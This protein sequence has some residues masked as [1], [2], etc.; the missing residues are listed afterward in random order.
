MTQSWKVVWYTATNVVNGD[1]KGW[2]TVKKTGVL[3][4]D[5]AD[6][7]KNKIFQDRYG[8]GQMIPTEN[9][10]VDDYGVSKITVRN[11][12]DILVSEGYLQK[13]SGKGTFVISNR[14]FNRLSKADS[15]SAMLEYEGNQLTKK[16]L[17]ISVG[18]E[19]TIPQEFEQAQGQITRIERVYYLDDKPF[20]LFTHYLRVPIEQVSAQFLENH[21]LYQVLKIAGISVK[22]FDDQFTVSEVS[23]KAKKV[24]R[25]TK[26]MGM[27]R[28]RRGFDQFDELV[29][30][31]EAVYN[32]QV[33][34]YEIQYEV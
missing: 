5:I 7:I 34:P 8:V 30:Y 12:V 14:P 27:E 32:T 20:I 28:I 11:A 13:K 33:H 24:L 23:P 4:R 18:E 1:G 26:P 22:R 2:D 19:G 25:I 29:E 10:L 17:S 21:S 9:E 16:I 3:Y 31:S 6:D 15:F